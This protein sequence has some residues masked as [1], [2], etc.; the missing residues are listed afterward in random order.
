MIPAVI[1]VLMTSIN[2]TC[3]QQPI[4]GRPK[5]R[6]NEHGY[7][8]NSPRE[9]KKVAVHGSFLM[10]AMA[11]SL[12]AFTNPFCLFSTMLHLNWIMRRITDRGVAPP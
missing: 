5:G 11:E 2:G 10:T 4:Y 9:F 12:C 6:A 3:N 7:P 8:Q 1:Q